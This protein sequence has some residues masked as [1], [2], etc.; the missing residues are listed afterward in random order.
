[1]NSYSSLAAERPRKAADW[2]SL[3]EKLPDVASVNGSVAERITAFCEQK[4]ITVDALSAL[5]T[6]VATRRGGSL[7]LAFAGASRDGNKITAVKYRPVGGGSHDSEAQTPSVWLSPITAGKLSAL[8]WFIA[9]GETDGARLYDLVGD[10][11]AILV[12]PAGARTFKPVWA[13]RIPRG[14]VVHLAHDAD[15]DGDEGAAAAAK[16]LGGSTVRLRPPTADW[17]DWRGTREEFIELVREARRAEEQAPWTP[18]TWSEFRDAAGDDTDWLIAGLLPSGQLIFTAAPPK[19]G[20][21]WLALVKALALST[22]KPLFGEYEIPEP[23]H[24]LYVALEGS[25][26]A[27]RARL[28]AIARGLGVDPAE[29]IERLHL[30]Y[31]PR[32]FDLAELETAGWL[33]EAVRTVD[34]RYVVIDVLRSAARIDEKDPADFARV[35][36]ALEPLLLE[37]RTV[38]LL[39]HFGKLTDTQKERLPGERMTGTGAMHGALD[40]GFYITKSENGA[41][42]LRVEIEARDF[43]SPDPLGVVILGTGSGEHG[44]FTYTDT[45]TFAIDA[46]AAE[47]RNLVDELETL[48]ADSEWRTAKEAATKQDGIGANV[49]DVKNALSGAP[50][51]FVCVDGPRVGRHV[52]AKPWGTLKMLTDIGQG[53]TPS[54]ESDESDNLFS[55]IQTSVGTCVSP[56]G[57]ETPETHVPNRPS[58]DSAPESDRTAERVA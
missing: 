13:D 38:D 8:D 47:D 56:Y 42:R 14:A 30:L 55:D 19:R 9:E 25:R 18:E 35:R 23:V 37:A 45:A 21:T 16:I 2:T 48:F 4:G 6:R 27:L 53:V 31:R 10:V 22:G 51:R 41:R 40:V 29:E 34:A 36:D 43:A 52:N 58:S 44:G 1:V 11:A 5:G 24:V 57:G 28:G 54:P 39:H 46:S 49:D 7:W 50:E 20:K 17:C 3:W 26:T 32:P 33:H 15:V 12:L